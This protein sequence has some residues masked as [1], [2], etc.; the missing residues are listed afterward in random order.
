MEEDTCGRLLHAMVHLD[1][2]N[3][4]PLQ[5]EKKQIDLLNIRQRQP[6]CKLNEM[7]VSFLSSIDERNFFAIDDCFVIEAVIDTLL[8]QGQTLHIINL[9]SRRTTT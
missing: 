3:M 5:R 8:A 1:Q 7:T 6:W 9:Q 2:Y 4:N